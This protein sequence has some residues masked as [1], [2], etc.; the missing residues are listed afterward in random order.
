[1]QFEWSEQKNATN[2]EKHGLDF[3][4]AHK[5]FDGYYLS[6]LDDREDYGEERHIA[7]GFIDGRVALVVYSEPREDTL[8]IISLRK[9]L[10]HE[11]RRFENSLK[12]ELGES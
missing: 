5:L 8:R 1:M 3:A 9:A 12:D 4:D 2:I 7:I 6:A 11:R 10:L